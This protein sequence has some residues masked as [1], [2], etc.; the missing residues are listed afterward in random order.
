MASRSSA[1]AVREGFGKPALKSSR[2]GATFVNWEPVMV[3]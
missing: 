3:A 1:R 2:K